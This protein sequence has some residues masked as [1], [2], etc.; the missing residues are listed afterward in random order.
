MDAYTYSEESLNYIK[1]L[2]NTDEAITVSKNVYL[3]LN[4]CD[5]TGQVTVNANANLYCMDSQTDNYDSTDVDCGKLTN[6]AQGSVV[7]A[8]PFGSVSAVGNEDKVRAGYMMLTN[9][10]GVS[11]HRYYQDVSYYNLQTTG[12]GMY[13]TAVFYGDEAIKQAITEKGRFGVALAIKDLADDAA[14]IAGIE[15]TKESGRTVLYSAYNGTSF[16]S[17]AEVNSTVLKNIMSNANGSIINDR[18]AKIRVYGR[19]YIQIGNQYYFGD[20]VDDPDGRGETDDNYDFNT[21]KGLVKYMNDKMWDGL[22]EAQK[23]A[24]MD[25]Y[26]RYPVVLGDWG[27]NNIKQAV[28]DRKANG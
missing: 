2:D 8:V 13:F 21:L 28:K 11:F 3:D 1:L 25:M 4:G 24:V 18:N 27:V 5:I 6:V 22:K 7:K 23:T 9:E 19:P 26:E 20:V 12:A 16:S 10:D 14:W 17:G 15:D